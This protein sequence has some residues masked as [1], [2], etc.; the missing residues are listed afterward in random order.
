M[1]KSVANLQRSQAEELAVD[2]KD[3]ANG[4][5]ISPNQRS[6]MLSNDAYLL[7]QQLRGNSVQ[8][9][10]ELA[11]NQVGRINQPSELS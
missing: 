4:V 10:S 11:S 5:S 9:H 3:S 1:A 2:F 6:S 8:A 7:Q